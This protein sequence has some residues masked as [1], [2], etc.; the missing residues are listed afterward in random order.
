DDVAIVAPSQMFFQFSLGWD[1]NHAIKVIGQFVEKFR[2]FHWL[3][4]PLLGFCA[5]FDF[6]LFL[7]NLFNRSRNCKRARNNLDFT[8]G[9]LSS[10]ASAVSSVERP[11]TSR[12]T[13][14]VRNVAGSPWIVLDRKSVV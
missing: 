10:S 11:S 2:A 1:V 12:N 13:N 4:S 6:S 14:T 7:K 5:P 9:I 8:A 3:P